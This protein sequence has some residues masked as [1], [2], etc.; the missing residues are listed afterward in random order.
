VA[1]AIP[2]G[3]CLVRLGRKSWFFVE[4]KSF[5]FLV[6]KGFVE[7]RVVE[8]RTGFLGWVLL[9]IRCVAWLLST[10]EEVL[11]NPGSEDFVNSFREGSKVTI[12]WRGGN[13]SGRFLEVAVYV[14]GGWRGMIVFFKGHD[15]RGWGRVSGELSKALAFF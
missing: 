12:V 10:V 2:F 14:M 15:G 1:A 13:S 5:I 11:R 9:G 7:L 4:A 3:G 6:V 8:K